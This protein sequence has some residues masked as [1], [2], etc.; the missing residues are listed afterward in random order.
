HAIPLCQV[1]QLLLL[2][3]HS[4]L[5]NLIIVGFPKHLRSVFAIYVSPYYCFYYEM[6]RL[7]TS[8]CMTFRFYEPNA[9]ALIHVMNDKY[10]YSC[11]KSL[12][13]VLWQKR[14][15]YG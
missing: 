7:N 3:P 6:K 14:K 1:D 13:F 2:Q 9:V 5:Y 11:S 8:V 12:I 15:N 10:K 4:V